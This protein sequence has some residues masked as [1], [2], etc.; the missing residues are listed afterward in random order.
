MARETFT[1]MW[2]MSAP[3]NAEG[4]FLRLSQTEYFLEKQDGYNALE[5]MPEVS[6]LLV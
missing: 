4:C 3:G 1:R 5:V 2:N 6:M